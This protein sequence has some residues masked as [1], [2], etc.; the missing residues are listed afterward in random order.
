MGSAKCLNQPLKPRFLKPAT[1]TIRMVI[2]AKAAVILMSLVGGF[3]SN[4]AGWPN[5]LTG[6]TMVSVFATI[7]NKKSSRYR[8]H[9]RTAYAQ[10]VLWKNR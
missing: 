8:G 2:I 5:T 7:K 10:I 4:N 1:M 9:T 6:E 3:N